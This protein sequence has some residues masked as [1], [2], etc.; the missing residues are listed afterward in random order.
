MPGVYLIE[1][2]SGEMHTLE[3]AKGM[4][5]GRGFPKQIAEGKIL[6]PHPLLSKPH[7][8][9]FLDPKTSRWWIKDVSRNGCW[10]NQKRILNSFSL[11]HGDEIKL[12]SYEF[13]FY[14][15]FGVDDGTMEDNPLETRNFPKEEKDIS[16]SEE[17]AIA[18]LVVAM[19]IFLFFWID[20]F[21]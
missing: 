3:E 21:F 16:F 6:L 19:S 9:I 8:Q 18:L 20:K 11:S 10:V 5:I 17:V 12:A 1:K 14:E 7:A 2:N 15:N 13:V 4:I